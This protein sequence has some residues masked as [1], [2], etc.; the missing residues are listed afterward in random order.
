M[1]SANIVMGIK[2]AHGLQESFNNF[3]KDVDEHC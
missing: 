1:T 3:A 2:N